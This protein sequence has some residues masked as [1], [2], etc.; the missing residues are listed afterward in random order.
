MKVP[1]YLLC[2]IFLF[3]WTDSQ[4]S[5]YGSDRK[6]HNGHLNCGPDI[7]TVSRKDGKYCCLY[8]DTCRY[9]YLQIVRF[10]PN[11]TVLHV[12]Q[13]CRGICG[14]GRVQCPSNPNYC[15]DLK[16]GFNTLSL[17]CDGQHRCEEYCSGSI[18]EFPYYNKTTNSSCNLEN[19]PLSQYCGKR[20][21]AKFHNFQCSAAPASFNPKL[22]YRCLNRMDIA[23]KRIRESAIYDNR[24]S[25]RKNLF[26]IFRA[27]S[28]MNSVNQ[29]HIVC[30]N[31]TL[32]WASGRAGFINCKT[33]SKE[34][35][36]KTYDVVCAFDFLQDR[37]LQVNHTIKPTSS[38]MYLPRTRYSLGKYV[39]VLSFD[40]IESYQ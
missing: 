30:G 14:D 29:T 32:Q 17:A 28:T 1:I 35:P 6:F 38:V 4:I 25:N 3:K 31:N 39:F 18:E 10:C 23:E 19:L 40:R 34:V 13:P 26:E 15:I 22:R 8:Q 21:G 12:Y 36:V 24:T 37:G 5:Q 11:A 33:E 16:P 27:N 2:C 7:Q 9:I 20:D